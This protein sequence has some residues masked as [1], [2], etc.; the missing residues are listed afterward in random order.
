[1]IDAALFV[2]TWHIATAIPLETIAY[3]AILVVTVWVQQH[4]GVKWQ[5]RVHQLEQNE[6]RLA[7]ALGATQGTMQ[8]VQQNLDARLAMQDKLIET[9]ESRLDRLV[10]VADGSDTSESSSSE[11]DE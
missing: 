7:S 5:E 1:M 9:L 2:W 11:A 8:M 3:A 4:Q 10:I 6:V